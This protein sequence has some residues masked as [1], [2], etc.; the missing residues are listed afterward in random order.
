MY[1]IR[2]DTHEERVRSG[3]SFTVGGVCLGRGGKVEAVLDEQ[4]DRALVCGAKARVRTLEIMVRGVVGR[5][6]S[7]PDFMDGVLIPRRVQACFQ[8]WA[9]DATAACRRLFTVPSGMARLSEI[10]A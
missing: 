6:S 9:N 3:E 1:W 2:L 8:L 4:V 10:C 7:E 5:H